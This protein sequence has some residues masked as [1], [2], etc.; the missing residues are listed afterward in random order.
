MS[1]KTNVIG[2]AINRIDG[3]LK[4]T[5]TANYAMD[6]PVNNVAFGYFF[7]SETAAGKILSID[8]S[9][10]EKADGVIAVITHEN[11]L[12]VKLSRSLRGGAIL[13]DADIEYFGEN[14]GIVVAET[15]EQARH[16]ARLVKVNYQKSAAKVD[17]EKEK[18]Q[19]QKIRT[20]RRRDSRRC[21]KSISECRV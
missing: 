14:I 15:F 6:F 18:N 16:A 9:A 5:G 4:V 21:R 7:K 3:I 2:E 20:A 1:R 13:Q 11:A 10:A 8:T 19:R 17:F 12:K